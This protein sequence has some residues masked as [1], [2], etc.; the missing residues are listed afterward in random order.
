MAAQKKRWQ[1]GKDSTGQRPAASPAAGRLRF[2]PT[3][4]LLV[5]AAVCALLIAGILMVSH[6]SGSRSDVVSG[7]GQQSPA[8]TTGQ[9]DEHAS[10]ATTTQATEPDIAA[11]LPDDPS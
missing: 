5:I 3:R 10:A 2:I 6:T 4:M 11:P 9:Q 1:A 8:I 7:S